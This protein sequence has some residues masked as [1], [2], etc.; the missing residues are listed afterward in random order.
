MKHTDWEAD[1]LEEEAAYHE[2]LLTRI[3]D[4]LC[5]RFLKTRVTSYIVGLDATQYTLSK[6]QD[7]VLPRLSA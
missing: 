1:D 4:A 3:P 7:S 6:L 2:K 5:Q